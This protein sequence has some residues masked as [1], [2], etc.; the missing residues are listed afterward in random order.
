MTVRDLVRDL[1][2]LDQD[3]RVLL[4]DNGLVLSL[5]S[6]YNDYTEKA[7]WLDVRPDTSWE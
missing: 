5:H 2:E 7:V 4:L 1:S 6:V 3:K